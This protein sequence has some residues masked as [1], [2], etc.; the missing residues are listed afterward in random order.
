M[1]Y[2]PRGKYVWDGWCMPRGSEV[3]LYHLQRDRHRSPDAAQKDAKTRPEDWLGHAVSTD[4]VNWEEREPCFGPNPDDPTDDDQPWTGCALWHGGRGHLFYTM[5][6]RENGAVQRIGLATSDDA[7][8]WVRHGAN[9]VIRP[10]ERWYANTARPVP[11]VVDCRDLV[12]VA[13]PKGGWLGFYATRQPAAE[14]AQTSV[15]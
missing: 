2:A 9:P 5:R 6:G 4:L 7:D 12:V 15:I 14:L 10:D 11:G 8:H 1:N 3:H 13:D